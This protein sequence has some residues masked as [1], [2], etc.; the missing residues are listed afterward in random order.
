MPGAAPTH[1]KKTDSMPR[2]SQPS[3]VRKLSGVAAATALALITTLPAFAGIHEWTASGG[4]PPRSLRLNI[5][6]SLE[7]GVIR[8]ILIH[9]NGVPDPNNWASGDDRHYATDPELV[10]FAE[11]IGFAVLATGNWGKFDINQTTGVSADFV[12]FNNRLAAFATESGHPELVHAPW[13]C[14]GFSNGGQM[15]YGLNVLAPSKVIAFAA[16]KGGYY[17]DDTPDA[18]ARATPGLLI[19]G[20]NDSTSRRNK[21][22]SI[23]NTNR[24]LGAKWAWVEE[25]NTSHQINNSYKLIRPFLAEC[26]RLRYPESVGLPTSGPVTLLTLTEESGWL[27]DQDTWNSGVTQIYAYGS[28]SGSSLDYGWVPNERLAR[29]YRAFSTYNKSAG[30]VGGSSIVVT[31]ALP[32]SLAF[33]VNMSG[34]TWTS[35][36]IF[37]GATSIATATSPGN[38]S[39]NHSA[40]TGGYHVFHGE[41]TKPGGAKSSTLL[42]PVFVVG[43]L[44]PPPEPPLHAL[45]DFGP[46]GTT[47]TGGDDPA[48]TWN[49]FTSNT[50]N[51]SLGLVDTAG[52]AT[53]ITLTLTNN[54]TGTASNGS[55]SPTAYV[56][57]AVRDTHYFDN[58]KTPQLKLSGLDPA[59]LYNLS[60]LGSRM[61]SDG[62]VRSTLFT[63]H[64]YATLSTVNNA[65]DNT[66]TVSTISNLLPTAAGEI[67][68]DLDDDVSNDTTT[69]VGYLGVLEITT[70]P[71]P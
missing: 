10:A 57:D 44:A 37:E 56:T 30:A 25:E 53:G 22:S 50:T 54:F 38:V 13:I 12:T 26:V 63:T 32:A 8:G 41:I 14:E 51:A 3:F 21:L 6:A 62:K 47:T 49:N 58:G 39:I 33:T 35:M 24:A 34:Q 61:A 55:T 60:F 17:N 42:H 16:N 7:N 40:L 15:A 68:I 4:N 43:P 9:G 45:V 11:S 23:F 71:N 28:Q 19:A 31:T 69:K 67:V 36:E 70:S 64:G 65:T 2:G 18:A 1:M 5:P 27:V 59:K 66:G 48:N 52:A 20:E 46:S 29:L